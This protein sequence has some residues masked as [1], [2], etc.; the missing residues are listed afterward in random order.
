VRVSFQVHS[1]LPFRLKLRAKPYFFIQ[2]FCLACSVTSA[3][4]VLLSFL[5]ARLKEWFQPSDLSPYPN[6]SLIRL[7]VLFRLASC[8]SSGLRSL[9]SYFPS[10]VRT[11]PLTASLIGIEG[12]PLWL[13]QVRARAETTLSKAAK[14]S[15]FVSTSQLAWRSIY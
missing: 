1:S 9:R 10:V 4:C 2:A 15:S 8:L 13:G 3:T 12:W 11:W 6:K 14:R 7:L 5:S